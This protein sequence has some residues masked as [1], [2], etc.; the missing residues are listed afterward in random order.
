MRINKWVYGESI[1][2]VGNKNICKSIEVN[3]PEQDII[4]SSARFIHKLI[5]QKESVS[6]KDYIGRPS[7]STSKL[8]HTK[9]KKKTWKTALEHH[10]CL[11]NQLLPN[12]KYLK[13][14]TFKDKLK[15]LSSSISHLNEKTTKS[16]S[17]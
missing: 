16:L 1:F 4:Q 9:P 8:F 11:Y 7:R 12:I 2:K 15:N 3:M 6:I 17:T 14:S 10:N 5:N 13:P